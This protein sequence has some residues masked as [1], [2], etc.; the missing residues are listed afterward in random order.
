MTLSIAFLKC[1][2]ICDLVADKDAWSKLFGLIGSPEDA[3]KSMELILTDSVVRDSIEW[4]WQTQG[5]G[6]TIFQL[7]QVHNDDISNSCR[8]MHV[9]VLYCLGEYA[10]T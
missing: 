10:T 6:Q 1:I 5:Y 7:V 4:D 9:I 2:C 8:G 3:H